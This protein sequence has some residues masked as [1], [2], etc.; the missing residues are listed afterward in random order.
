[1]K[2]AILLA[3]QE[4]TIKI[5]YTNQPPANPVWFS[6]AIQCQGCKVVERQELGSIDNLFAG[7]IAARISQGASALQQQIAGAFQSEPTSQ[8]SSLLPCSARRSFLV[9]CGPCDG[10]SGEL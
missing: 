9:A 6:T 2:N 3:A 5:T 7:Q 1:M 4:N 8:D 10:K